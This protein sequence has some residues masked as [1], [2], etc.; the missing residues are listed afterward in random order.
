MN[1]SLSV[2]SHLK[3]E[4]ERVCE[5]GKKIRRDFCFKL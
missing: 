1:L 3:K 4:S 2:L 5:R